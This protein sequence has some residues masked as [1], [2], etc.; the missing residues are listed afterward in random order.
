MIA[1]SQVDHSKVVVCYPHLVGG[2]GDAAYRA[3]S[4]HGG[5]LDPLMRGLNIPGSPHWIRTNATT[6][7]TSR[8]AITLAGMNPALPCA[9]D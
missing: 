2:L 9:M 5:L 3:F 4:D 1:N 7:K 8:A 6:A